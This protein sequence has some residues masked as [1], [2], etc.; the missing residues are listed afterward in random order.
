MSIYVKWPT[1]RHRAFGEHVINICI[2]NK[3]GLLLKGSIS[4]NTAGKYSDIDLTVY[5]RFSEAMIDSI[6]YGFERPLMIN[7]SENPPGLL[8][9]AYS[10][11]L[12]IDLGIKPD[13]GLPAE[14]RSV[15][16]VKPE[17]ISSPPDRI[18]LHKYINKTASNDEYSRVLKL[19]HKGLLKGLNGKIRESKEFLQEISAL[20]KIEIKTEDDLFE[21][22]RI[23]K[24]RFTRPGQDINKELAWL[25]ENAEKP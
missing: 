19:I 4:G 7:A 12:A 24:E 10:R 23:L 14:D 9:V 18:S 17:G 5:G 11:G 15:I 25:I 6:L 13:A 20:T 8:I 1:A 3:A 22:Y 2:E 21:S 16:L